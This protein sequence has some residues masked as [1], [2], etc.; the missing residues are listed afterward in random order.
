VLYN[1]PRIMRLSVAINRDILS[2]TVGGV[3]YRF[4]GNRR[5]NTLF[6]EDILANYVRESEGAGYAKEMEEIGHKWGLLYSTSVMMPILKKIPP[7]LFI[8]TIMRPVW[9]NLGLL[10]DLHAV[11]EGDIVT[12]ETKNECTTRIIGKSKFLEGIYRGALETVFNSA[13]VTREALQ[14]KKS[15]RYSFQ[16]TY[17]N[18]GIETK[19]KKV[20][21][22]LNHLPQI[23][24]FTLR[25]ALK[26]SIFKLKENNKI[27]FRGTHI[28]L[29]ENTL[30]H[31]I[32]NEKILLDRIQHISFSYFEKLVEKDSTHEKK[33]KLLK[34]LLQTMGW[35]I[36]KIIIEDRNN[37]TFKISNPPHGFQIEEDN[38]EFLSRTI[39]GFL[40]LLD[41]GFKIKRDTYESKTLTIVYSV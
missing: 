36:M 11:K 35:G 5:R 23:T 16:L 4:K 34:T 10:D 12:F 3:F 17:K 31:I 27:F 15:S 7:V 22:K 39:L 6:F 30:F 25:D 41:T 24:G 19:E 2:T 40:W 29:M 38:W 9:A 1:G 33:I 13:I 32:G 8:N 18:F 21:D 20:Y 14:T 37:I 26:S 28:Q